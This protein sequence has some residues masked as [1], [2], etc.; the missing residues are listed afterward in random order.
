[1]ND[2]VDDITRLLRRVRAGD[3]EAQ[4]PLMDAVYPEL[5]RIASRIFRA[6]GPGHTLEPSALIGDVWLR[7]LHDASI[8][9]Q[10][11][12]HFY[13]VAVNTMR[14]TLVDY[15][16]ARNAQRRPNR[17]DRLPLEDVVVVSDDRL[18]EILELHEAVERLG[19]RHG[20]AA[21]VVEL[22]YYGGYTLEEIAQILGVSLTTVKNRHELAMAWLEAFLEGAAL[23]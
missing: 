22:R 4:N 1:M 9:W 14:Q 15:A 8:D 17:N 11:R 13:R 7:I 6:E 23:D 5:Q 2:R 19:E 20:Q 18:N 3:S 21:A 10:S 12:T 16:R